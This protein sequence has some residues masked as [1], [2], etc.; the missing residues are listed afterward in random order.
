MFIN[1]SQISQVRWKGR[2]VILPKIYSPAIKDIQTNVKTQLTSLRVL[3]RLYR[4]RK[5]EGIWA[6]YYTSP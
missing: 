1:I 4:N 6:F 2:K 5:G 3:S